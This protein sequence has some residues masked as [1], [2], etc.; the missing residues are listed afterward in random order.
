MIFRTNSSR[1]WKL[2]PIE[3]GARLFIHLVRADFFPFSIQ[4]HFISQWGCLLMKS[5]RHGH[6]WISCA[7]VHQTGSC[8]GPWLNQPR[9]SIIT[10][11]I[12]YMNVECR[13]VCIYLCGGFTVTKH[14][15]NVASIEDALDKWWNFSSNTDEYLR[16]QR[17]RRRINL[18]MQYLC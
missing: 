17:Q 2:Y 8:R 3:H 7:S 4:W 9:I 14:Y 15:V 13:F 11:H 18:I 12:R 10:C 1:Y 5:S 6:P 16:R